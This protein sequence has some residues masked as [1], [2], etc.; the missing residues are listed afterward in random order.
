MITN[1]ITVRVT[2]FLGRRCLWEYYHITV[3]DVIPQEEKFC[4]DLAHVAG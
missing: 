3:T 4:T 2:A 1:Y